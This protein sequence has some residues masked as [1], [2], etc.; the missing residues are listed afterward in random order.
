M[1][2]RVVLDTNCLLQSISRKGRYYRVWRAFL[3]GEYDLCITTDIL[4]EYEEIIGRYTSP[5][6]GRMLVEAILRASNT[7]RV[8]AHF[9]FGL[10]VSDPD[11]NIFRYRSFKISF[12]VFVSLRE[13]PHS[14][15]FVVFP[16][17]EAKPLLK[18]AEISVRISYCDDFGVVAETRFFLPGHF[19]L[20]NK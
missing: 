11:D 4:E 3:D 16:T 19:F 1:N 8:D 14:E 9:R 7:L 17:T 12:V 13:V 10:I 2:R 20:L 6:V 18:L 5:L 15:D